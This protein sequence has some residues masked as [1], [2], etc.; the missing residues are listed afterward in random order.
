MIVESTFTR[1]ADVVSSMRWGWLAVGPL[2]TQRFDSA[3][4]VAAIGSPLLV[5]HGKADPLIP[6][7]LGQQLF[8]AAQEPKRLILVEGATHHNTQ[9]KAM[10]QYRLALQELFGLSLAKSQR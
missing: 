4:K 5:V 2:I 3:A 1:I 9:T 8:E 6:V 7:A 10:E